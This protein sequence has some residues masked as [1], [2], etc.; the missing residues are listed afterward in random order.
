M[1]KRRGA[2][3]RLLFAAIFL[4]SIV[5][6]VARQ[7]MLAK[8]QHEQV[9]AI[10]S[11]EHADSTNTQSASSALQAAPK[12]GDVFEP[13]SLSLSRLET[14]QKCYV[15][16]I[17]YR[18]HFDNKIRCSISRKFNLEYF[19]VGKAGS[20]TCRYVMK[21]SFDAKEK[22]CREQDLLLPSSSNMIRFTFFRE[23]FSRFISSYQEALM[24]SLN[25]HKRVPRQYFE[26][27]IIPP[28]QQMKKRKYKRLFHN[29]TGRELLMNGLQTFV[30]AY[31]AERPFDGHLR[32]Q[33]PRL[34]NQ[35]TGRTFPLTAVF[36]THNME[37]DF[38]SLGK[39][40][41]V[42]NVKVIHAYNRGDYRLNTTHL[43][44]EAKRKIC[45]LSAI[46]YCCLNYKL[47]PECEGAVTCQ[48]TKKDISKELLI[49]PISPYPPS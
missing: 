44:E 42:T 45:Q 15:D 23:P 34:T 47:P 25:D 38:E 18:N 4:I 1:K 12:H 13:G 28:F 10:S 16:P 19:M 30:N 36:D 48:W 27:L 5:L 9:Y 26:S 40:V 33:I 22:G 37:R 32:L 7:S 35:N 20:S 3:R 11:T 17:K 31:D 2:E 49:E 24:R 6:L 46:D 39:M 43:N 8:L 29:E 21:N 41:N 14:Y